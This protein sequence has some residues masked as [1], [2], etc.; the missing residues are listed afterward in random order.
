MDTTFYSLLVHANAVYTDLSKYRTNA[1]ISISDEVIF[2]VML[3]RK[4]NIF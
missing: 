3:K 4:L 1:I 2:L